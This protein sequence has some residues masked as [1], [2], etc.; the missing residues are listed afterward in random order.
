MSVGPAFTR[1]ATENDGGA[2][3]TARTWKIQA[4]PAGVGTTI[5]TAAALSWTPATPGTYTLRYS[6]TN[7]VGTGTDDVVVTATS[8]PG[9]LN[10]RWVGAVTDGAI[11]VAVRTTN[12]T[13]VRLAV[14]T[15]SSMTSPVYS[16]VA[17]PDSNGNSKVTV[18]G[19]DP[20]TTYTYAI[21]MNGTLDA[22]RAT[23][24]TFPAAGVATSFNFAFGS[25]VN[26]TDSEAFARIK[27]RNPDLF[28]HLGDFRY[29][30][31]FADDQSLFRGIYNEALAAV[32]E[33]AL[34]ESTPTAYIWSDHDFAGGSNAHAGAASKPAAQAVYRQY[35]PHYPLPDAAGIYQTFVVG[36]VRFILTDTRSYRSAYDATDN[37]TKTMMGAT[38]KQWFKD[39]ITNATEK[40]IVWGCE[41]PW[42]TP[43]ATG[44]DKWGSYN[45]ERQE[46]AS[47]IAASGKKLVVISGDAHELAAD[48]GTNGAGGIPNW[49]AAPFNNSTNP[50]GGPWSDG[51]VTG[52][53]TQ[54]FYGW[55]D[56]TDNGTTLT[57]TFTGYDTA[58]AA[59]VTSSVTISDG[60][61]GTIDGVRI[62]GS[63]PSAVYVGSQPAT[64]IYIGDTKVWP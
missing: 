22:G 30:N 50:S 49:V 52:T 58:D 21:E 48:N 53:G 5:G 33:K 16:S 23:A 63:S 14:S 20:D 42:T 2:T 32:N 38:Q 57:A 46:L 40:L 10:S 62:G 47:F 15:S 35:V 7:S 12:A 6:A 43:I 44:D 28:V 37:A 26:A 56:V 31:P 27:A 1:T 41:I 34:Y 39:T 4:G 19:L 51:Q 8:V 59:R 13:S 45:T 64:A 55:V 18:S 3:I 61:P 54:R 36:R 60:A 9:T 11:T 29:L 25:C 24:R 17:T